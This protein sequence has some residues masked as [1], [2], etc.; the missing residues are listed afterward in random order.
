MRIVD[1]NDQHVDEGKEG[2]FL[3][4]GPVVTTGYF[5]N[6]EATAEAFTKDGWFRTGDIGL[7]RDGKFYIVD[8]KKV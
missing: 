7:R 3:I 6:E 2:E 8:R 5:E 1:D 4:K